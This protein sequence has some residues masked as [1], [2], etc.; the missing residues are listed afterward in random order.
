MFSRV[1]LA[2]VLVCLLTTPTSAQSVPAVAGAW[3]LR[4]PNPGTFPISNIKSQTITIT[5]DGN[6]IQITAKTNDEESVADLIVDGK[7]RASPALAPPSRPE[8]VSASWDGSSLV[9]KVIQGNWVSG[10]REA[11]ERWSPSPD[12][13]TL[14]R[15]WS[16][17]KSLTMIY[18]RRPVQ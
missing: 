10:V 4:V 13:R 16:T 15:S 17:F 1:A 18:D 2:C 3:V 9:L 11:T 8:Y 6:R 14:T 7:E 5:C 12:G